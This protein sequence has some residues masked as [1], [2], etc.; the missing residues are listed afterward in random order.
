MNDETRDDRVMPPPQKEHKMRRVGMT[1]EERCDLRQRAEKW[2]R[3]ALG[4][5]V[6][7]IPW[8]GN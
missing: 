6:E 2:V 4:D 1:D 7:I 3:A 8:E 5:D